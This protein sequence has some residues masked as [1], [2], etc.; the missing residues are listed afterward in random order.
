[1]LPVF[2]ISLQRPLDSLT[3]DNG[4]QVVATKDMVIVLQLLG[5][6]RGWRPCV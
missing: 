2:V 5:K 1:M 6:V 3:F 4:Q